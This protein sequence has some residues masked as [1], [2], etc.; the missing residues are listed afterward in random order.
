M[1]CTSATPAKTCPSTTSAAWPASRCASVSP[2]QT[3]GFSPAA[4]AACTLRLTVSSVSPKSWRRSECPRIT[5]WHRLRSISG[6]TS[7]VKAPA[8]SKYMFWAP[9]MTGLPET[10]CR[11][12]ASEMKGGQR[13]I[14]TLLESGAPAATSEANAAA[15]SSVVFIFQLPATMQRGMAYIPSG[16]SA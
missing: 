8:S 12:A 10:A 1:S 7:P 15:S 5:Y 2:T 14:S 16:S 6:D 9:T 13:M 11:T 3:M 4:K